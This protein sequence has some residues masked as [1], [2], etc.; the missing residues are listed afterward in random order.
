MLLVATGIDRHRWVFIVGGI[1]KR[2]R[3]ATMTIDTPLSTICNRFRRWYFV[4]GHP[5]VYGGLRWLLIDTT[6]VYCWRQYTLVKNVHGLLFEQCL[7]RLLPQLL[8]CRTIEIYWQPWPSIV[9]NRVIAVASPTSIVLNTS[10]VWTTMSLHCYGKCVLCPLLNMFGSLTIA[11]DI[12]HCQTMA[13]NSVL[14]RTFPG[15][16]YRQC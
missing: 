15:L 11:I 6:A 12:Q 14:I 7:S 9:T 2:R 3:S 10:H 5:I 1:G 8:L 13:V 16:V 4:E